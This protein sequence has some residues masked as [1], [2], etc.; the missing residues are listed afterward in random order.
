[1]ELNI[2][3]HKVKIIY[4]GEKIKV[5]EAIIDAGYEIAGEEKV[6]EDI[7]LIEMQKAKKKMW[8][9]WL[10]AI[11]IAIISLLIERVLGVENFV[12]KILPLILA[13]P[14]LFIVGY[15]TIRSAVKSIKYF[16]LIWMF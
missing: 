7:D 6:E 10:F 16:S 2:N 9:A 8:I 1:M 5:R 11:P 4:S 3:M 12:I 15:P 13:F 14:I